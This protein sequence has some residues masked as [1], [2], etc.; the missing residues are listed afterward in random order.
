LQATSDAS[1]YF[2]V[3]SIFNQ[4]SQVTPLHLVA[5]GI[6]LVALIW[7]LYTVSHLH[8]LF[9]YM[10]SSSGVSINKGVI[11]LFAG[12]QIATCAVLW[13]FPATIAKKLLPSSADTASSK[14]PSTLIEWQ[15]F[16]VV[17]IGIWALARAIPDAIYWVTFY[18]MTLNSSYGYSDL[19][20]EQK[21]SMITT[22]VEL[23][24]GMWLVFG[25]R[26]LANAL[27]KLRTAGVSK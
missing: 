3:I 10:N 25:A 18:G 21:A 16:G 22:V 6:R 9:A 17:C 8:G 23:I 11:W 7:V 19:N 20:V 4:G 12:L 24:I 5:L 1:E 14:P 27:L 26:G 13:V 15:T 2:R